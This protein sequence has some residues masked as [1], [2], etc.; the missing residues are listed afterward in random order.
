[1]EATDITARLNNLKSQI[2][3]GKTEKAKA[4]ANLETY[5]KQQEELIAQLGQ[6]GVTPENLDA[7]ISKLDQEIAGNLAEAEKLL[8]PP[9]PVFSHAS[10]PAQ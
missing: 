9:V 10:A 3:I 2:E 7:E 5:T 8:A 6:L 1:M 4:Q